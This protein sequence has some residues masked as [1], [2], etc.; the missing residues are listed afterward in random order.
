MRTFGAPVGSTRGSVL[1]VRFRFF[2]TSI[3]QH[4]RMLKVK[5]N[6]GLLCWLGAFSG[7]V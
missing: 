2:T 6:L 4:G 7:G 1:F 5:R 3:H